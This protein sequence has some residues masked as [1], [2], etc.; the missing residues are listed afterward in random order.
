MAYTL[1]L[2]VLTIWTAPAPNRW[3]IDQWSAPLALG[4]SCSVFLIASFS[5]WV[6]FALVNLSFLL[7]A[8][9]GY[10]IGQKGVTLDQNTIAAVL[11]TTTP[12]AS[13]FV[14]SKL[15]LTAAVAAGL[16]LTVTIAY[17]STIDI[18]LSDFHRGRSLR[19]LSSGLS[20]SRCPS[21]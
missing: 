18:A 15:L 5:R 17:V 20:P 21:R 11:E 10:F 12:E 8:L 4:A 19:H 6:F 1:A 9:A 3:W 14:S 16:G 2:A 7:A 13:E